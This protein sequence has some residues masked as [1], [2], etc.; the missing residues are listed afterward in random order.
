[1]P[2]VRDSHISLATLLFKRLHYLQEGDVELAWYAGGCGDLVR[3]G[4]VSQQTARVGIDDNF[5][6]GHHTEPKHKCALYLQPWRRML[7][8]NGLQRFFSGQF[9]WFASDVDAAISSCNPISSVVKFD[10]L[11]DEP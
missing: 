8:A 7:T 11:S 6:C 5:L 1:M 2:G 3:P 9:L 4:A 10:W